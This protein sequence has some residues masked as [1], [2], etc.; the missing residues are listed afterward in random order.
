[1]EPFI[2]HELISR[3]GTDREK[4]MPILQEIAEVQHYLTETDMIQVAN[5]LS[6]SAAEVYGT[7]SF[8]SF[9]PIHSKGRYAI[10]LCKSIIA[11]M[12]G[13]EAIQQAITQQL[14]IKPGETT[15]D[16]MFSLELVNDIGWSDQE[17]SMLINE[18][19]Y[20]L[21]TPEKVRQVINKLLQ[22]AQI[23]TLQ[24]NYTQN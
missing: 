9:L 22:Q 14:G 13:S 2:L 10:R 12:K 3:H 20:T 15:R 17:P 24:A 18:K 21:L 8:Y 6:L 5:A 4:L 1:M 7:A 19:A 11:K 16:G 23:G